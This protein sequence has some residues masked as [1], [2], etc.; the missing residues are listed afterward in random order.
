V[1]A[2]IHHLTWGVFKKF[3]NENAHCLLAS[4]ESRDRAE[5]CA[6]RIHE[7]CQE[8]EFFESVDVLPLEVE[9]PTLTPE[10]RALIQAARQSLKAHV[11]MRESGDA[12]NYPEQPEE[13]A[14]I[15]AL[16]PFAE[17]S[18]EPLRVDPDAPFKAQAEEGEG[19]CCP[20]CG[21]HDLEG[22]SWEFA[23]GMVWQAVTCLDC[24]S[25]WDENYTFRDITDVLNMIEQDKADE[26]SQPTES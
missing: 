4:F 10:V 8:D 20:V 6:N 19:C 9:P 17:S 22:D 21:K 12:G 1:K 14:L 3:K 11:S 16:A 23:A 5:D 2:T 24:G 13:T 18:P 15:A 26:I 7:E 25:S